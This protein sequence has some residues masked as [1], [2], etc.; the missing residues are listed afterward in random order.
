LFII[1]QK[2]LFKYYFSEKI[3]KK[4]DSL[5]ERA[6]SSRFNIHIPAC[7]ARCEN[8]LQN[9]LTFCCAKNRHSCNGPDLHTPVKK[10]LRFSS[11]LNN[12]FTV[13]KH[14]FAVQHA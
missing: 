5:S 10:T 13:S 7:P 2:P 11:A 4:P 1:K 6:N 8:G 14:R 12:K 9:R 3:N